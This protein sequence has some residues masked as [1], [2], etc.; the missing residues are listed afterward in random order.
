MAILAIERCYEWLK[1]GFR[2]EI[3]YL[4]AKFKIKRFRFFNDLQFS[5]LKTE[6]RKQSYTNPEKEK[7]NSEKERE[8]KNLEIIRYFEESD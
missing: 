5:P 7:N 2:G 8:N 3:R 1:R 4:L 6:K